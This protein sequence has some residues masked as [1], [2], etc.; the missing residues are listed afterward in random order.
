MFRRY[1]CCDCRGAEGKP[2]SVGYSKVETVEDD[3]DESGDRVLDDQFNRFA[4]AMA[5]QDSEM[6][7]QIM[8]EMG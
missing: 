8:Q 4:M 3:D 2:G 1:H 6:A 5:L 7:Q